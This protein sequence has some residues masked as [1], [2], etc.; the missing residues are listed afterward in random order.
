[1]A[2]SRPVRLDAPT[3]SLRYERDLIR[4][5]VAHDEVRPEIAASMT[6]WADRLTAEID[7]RNA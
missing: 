5:V 6:A 7:Q 3:E 4:D 1:M 2:Q